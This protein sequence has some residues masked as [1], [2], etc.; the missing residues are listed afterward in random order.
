MAD[1]V[2]TLE[3]RL[4]RLELLLSADGAPS[5]VA[6]LDKTGEP[7]ALE[8][9]FDAVA[10]EH[11]FEDHAQMADV[12][13]TRFVGVSLPYTAGRRVGITNADQVEAFSAGNWT[14]YEHNHRKVTEADQPK[15]SGMSSAN[16]LAIGSQAPSN[17]T[18]GSHI[19]GTHE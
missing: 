18:I 2:K 12:A 9:Q 19:K 6:K 7:G 10:R 15:K 14:P 13:H 11:K 4:A 16:S 8:A 3:Q 17:A 1:G 5:L